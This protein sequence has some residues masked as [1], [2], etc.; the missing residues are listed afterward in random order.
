MIIIISAIIGGVSGSILLAGIVMLVIWKMVST[1][2]DRREYH[3]FLNNLSIINF[4][5]NNPLFQN[6]TTNVKNPMYR[7]GY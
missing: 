7:K 1:Y 2:H 3:K 4:N 5:G 6:L